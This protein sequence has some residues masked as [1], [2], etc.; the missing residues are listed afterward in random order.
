MNLIIL[1]CDVVLEDAVP[2][3]CENSPRGQIPGLPNNAF[4]LLLLLLLLVLLLPS[5][6]NWRVLACGERLTK[7]DLV[8]LCARLGRDEL[9][10]VADGVVGVALDSNLERGTSGGGRR[11][12]AR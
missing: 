5:P 11:G 2:L 1:Q 10:E 6:Q 8:G 3:F 7:P 9:L 12:E 4:V